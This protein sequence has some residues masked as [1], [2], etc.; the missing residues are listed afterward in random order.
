[1]ALKLKNN[2]QVHVCHM[3]K[4]WLDD[5]KVPYILMGMG[6]KEDGKKKPR[7]VTIGWMQ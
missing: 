5:R 6:E 2:N 4:D 3:L 7:G 1:M